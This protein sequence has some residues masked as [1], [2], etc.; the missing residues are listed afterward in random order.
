MAS[1]HSTYAWLAV[2]LATCLLAAAPAIA[3]ADDGRESTG[4][5]AGSE[6]EDT[7]DRRVSFDVNDASL[8]DLTFWMS[9]LT[10]ENFIL[11]DK[12]LENRKVTIYAPEPVTIE[13]ACEMFVSALRLQG[14]QVENVGAYWKI[15]A[16]K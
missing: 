6:V 14:L 4:A 3:T 11:L 5:S 8:L 2:A 15:T 10:G 16:L 7:E 12:E 9:H 1:R 13:E